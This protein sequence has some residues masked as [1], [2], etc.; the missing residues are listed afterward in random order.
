MPGR[1]PC[2]GHVIYGEQLRVPQRGPLMT[3]QR[4]V[5]VPT[6]AEVAPGGGT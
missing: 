6:L 2:C 3:Q 4:G 1:G 5:S